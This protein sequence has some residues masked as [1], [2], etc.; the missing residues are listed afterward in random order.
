VR[1]LESAISAWPSKIST[2]FDRAGA[3]HDGQN[4]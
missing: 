1:A 3:A 4:R 2:S